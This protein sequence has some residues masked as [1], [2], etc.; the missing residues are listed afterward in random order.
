MAIAAAGNCCALGANRDEAVHTFHVRENQ[1]DRGRRKIFLLGCELIEETLIV[2]MNGT[3]EEHD[4][5]NLRN[6]DR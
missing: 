6:R 3:Q 5:E 4:L 2:R 1:I